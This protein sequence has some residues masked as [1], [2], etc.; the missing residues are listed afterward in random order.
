MKDSAVAL[1]MQRRP[2]RPWLVAGIVTFLAAISLAVGWQDQ[3]VLPLA[4]LGFMVI[5]TTILLRARNP[6]GWLFDVIALGGATLTFLET[7]LYRHAT[8]WPGLPGAAYAA[9]FS[10]AAVV[11]VVAALAFLLLVFPN[12]HLPSRR[13]VPVGWAISVSTM[14]VVLGLLLRPGSTDA[15]HAEGLTNPM[16]SVRF[17]DLVAVLGKIGAW[18]LFLGAL[19]C[20]AS[21]VVRF[22]RS[23]GDERQQLRWLAAA[24]ALASVFFVLTGL[25]GIVHA[26][27][28][29][30]NITWGAFFL[31]LTFGVPGAVAVAVLK[32]RLYDIDVVISKTVLFGSLAAFITAVYVGIVVGIGALL[33]EQ[34][35]A[36]IGLSIIATAVV[37]V[38]FQPVRERMTRVANKLVYGERATPYQVLS[39]FAGRVGTTYASENVLPRT[40]RVIA[41]G[42]GAER[43]DVWLRVGNEIRRSASWPPEEGMAKRLPLPAN[44]ESL[45]EID[46]V[47]RAVPVL[48]QG[49]LIGAVTVTK[50]AGDPLRHAEEVL[51]DDLAS[52]AGLV[53]ANARLT[54]ELQARL[55]ELTERSAELLRSRQRIVT[56]Q[57]EERRR[58]ER[59]IH[60][61]AQQH[62]VALAVKL[63]LVR[64]LI[65]RDGAKAA[66]LLSELRGEVDDALETLSNLALGIYP[67]LLEEQGL[68]TALAA[69][70]QRMDLEVRLHT[71]GAGRYPIDL[72]AA[73]YFCTLEALQNI[74]KYAQ[75]RVV[76]I[77]I[78][79][80]Q[81]ALTFEVT[82]N[83]RGFDPSAAPRGSGLNNMHD[84]LSVLGGDVTVTSSEGRGTTVRGR[85]PLEAAQI[86]AGAT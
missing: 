67:P 27:D 19:A 30:G 85:V 49:S 11:P 34:G 42:T 61:G 35:H 1:P 70:Y 37:A 57:D 46:G 9:M 64:S 15:N 76:D 58:L 13:W 36:N 10:E 12:G 23:T 24:G 40:A 55:D 38:G 31:S 39:E 8:S 26:P 80:D 48:L 25:A 5:G 16:G 22:R 14:L 82:D 60:D 21:L 77:T 33:G 17:G 43:A 73:V 29:V 51:L 66:A 6:I 50:A 28:V 7:Y 53:L 69:Q 52:Q 65:S 18:G 83:G 62:L 47:D 32:Y 63:R 44:G 74:A 81:G 68:A 56:A 75:A 84:R 2:Y 72:E 78:G 4:P 71:N 79:E 59:N 41:E 20:V 86:P 45:P 3:G 54:A